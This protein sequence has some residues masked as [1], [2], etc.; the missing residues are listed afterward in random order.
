MLS[1]TCK[2]KNI[3]LSNLLKDNNNNPTFAGIFGW[4][5]LNTSFVQNYEEDGDFAPPDEIF[6]N[7]TL[8]VNNNAYPITT[9]LC[10]KIYRNYHE[11]I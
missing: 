9:A 11:V 1:E 7:N 10:G 2:S 4:M 5:P 8:S 3:T 6:H